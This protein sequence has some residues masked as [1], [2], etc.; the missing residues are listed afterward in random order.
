MSTAQKLHKTSC[1]SQGRLLLD[2][3]MTLHDFSFLLRVTRVRYRF[4]LPVPMALPP[5]RNCLQCS[6]ICAEFVPV[7]AAVC[8]L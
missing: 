2:Y 4:S 3:Y 7:N 8:V 1:F 5:R 6:G